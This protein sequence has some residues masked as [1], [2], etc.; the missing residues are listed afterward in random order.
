L[1]GVIAWAG[2]ASDNI[3][4]KPAPTIKPFAIISAFP[5]D[6]FPCVDIVQ[7]LHNTRQTT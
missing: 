1:N 6:K 2:A 7:T 4:A 5:F 3:V